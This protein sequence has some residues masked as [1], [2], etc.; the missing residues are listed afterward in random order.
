VGPDADTIPA[1]EVRSGPS[2]GTEN[3]TDLEVGPR[4]SSQ[5]SQAY[6]VFPVVSEVDT[7]SPR[8]KSSSKT[9][10]RQRGPDSSKKKV[11]ALSQQ[12]QSLDFHNTRIA[13]L[14]FARYECR[15]DNTFKPET[16]D[17]WYARLTA[18]DVASLK[19]D[20]AVR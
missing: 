6:I 11:K 9:F 14:D 10:K 1:P 4:S 13:G 7:L 2:T 17:F 16:V 20:F 5:Q 19:Q 12:L 8:S 15:L 18:N 3:D